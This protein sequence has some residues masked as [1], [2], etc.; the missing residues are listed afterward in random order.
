MDI[1]IQPLSNAIQDHQCLNTEFNVNM[2]IYILQ[3]PHQN[4]QNVVAI[5]LFN[6]I[7][8]YFTMKMP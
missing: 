5:F 4:F 2:I 1:L 7:R 3:A 6:K 8:K